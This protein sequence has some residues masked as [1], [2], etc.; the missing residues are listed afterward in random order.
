MERSVYSPEIIFENEDFVALNKPPGLL[1]IPDREG[2]EESLKQILKEKYGSI[3][4][5]HRIDRDTSGLIVFA[6]NGDSHRFLSGVFE[7][8]SVEKIYY[9]F[10][11]GSPAAKEGIIEA[12]IM[13][14]PVR[15]GVMV[16]NRKGKDS[17]TDY[18]VL[19]NFGI[20]SYLKFRILTG[21]T[22]Q[23]RVHMQHLGF[24]IVCDPIYGNG[25]PVLVSGFKKKYKLSRSEDVEKPILGRLGLH[26][27]SLS[28]VDSGGISRFLEAPLPRDMQA[29]LRQLE[30][31]KG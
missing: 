3:Y 4:T 21:R 6:K 9:G 27:A 18:E 8:R 5:V 10:V 20:Y 1:S 25:I 30:K 19:R 29:L 11:N 13:E 16:I 23:I 31:W 15:P 24:P 2:R 22:H 12:P 7:G 17:R 14:H 26:S 28:F